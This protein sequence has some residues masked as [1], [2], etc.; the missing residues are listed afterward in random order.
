M[1]HS[2][3]FHAVEVGDKDIFETGGR[4]G[5]RHW[6][7][8]SVLL[9]VDELASLTIWAVAILSVLFALFCLVLG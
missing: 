1:C 6:G 7:G 8:K 9:A 3:R 5:L 2:S 4:G